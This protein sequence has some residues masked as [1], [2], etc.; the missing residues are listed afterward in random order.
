MD[1]RLPRL[2]STIDDLRASIR[3][4]ESRIAALERREGPAAEAPAEAHAAEDARLAETA[5]PDA[6]D[7]RD[8]IHVLSLLGRLFICLGGGFFLRAMT[9]AGTVPPPV[10]VALGLAYGLVWLVMADRAAGTPT[11][12]SAV[13]HGIA[14]ALVAYPL[15]VEAT[16]KFHV[17][18]AAGAAALIAALTAGLLVVAWRRLLQPLAWIAVCA[19][20]PTSIL[21]LAQTGAVVPHAFF[22]ITLGVATLWMGYSLDWLLVRW[23]VALAADLVVFGVTMRALGQDHLESPGMALTVQMTLLGAYL[24]S[25]ALRTLVRGR[26]VIPFEVVQTSAALAVGLG[27]AVSVTRATGAGWAT[28]GI[29]SAVF[30]AA[31]YGVAFAFIERQQHR[32]RNV[33]FYTTLALVL[34]LVGLTVLLPEIGLVAALAALAVVS[35][36]AWSR[37]GRLFL[38]LH[39]AAYILAAALVSDTIGYVTHALGSGV[40]AGWTR[41][42]VPMLI[43]LGASAA[44]AWLAAVQPE[45]AASPR[46]RFP[47]FAVVLVFVIAAGGSV[48]GALAPTLGRLPDGTLDL[49]ILATVRTGVLA[50]ATLAVA[51]MGSHARF[52]EWGWHVYPLLVGIG[53]KM[54]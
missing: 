15:V 18:P 5:P 19:A 38:L 43:V 44:C 39:G 36:A 27:G 20:V 47:R 23:P 48:I 52:R 50:L 10:G 35:C 29:A 7:W 17:V 31:C 32:G 41:P 54:L 6:R 49:G 28:L 33:Y 11:P 1:D 13:F 22:L 46:A 26:N 24:F 30:G 40:T 4:L 9:E 3:A 21:L 45:E 16:T 34:V 42:S 51:W 53:L 37:V 2:E 12:T 8:P 25:I 14:A